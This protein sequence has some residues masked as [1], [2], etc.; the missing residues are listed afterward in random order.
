MISK[1]IAGLLI[2]TSLIC[3]PL[4]SQASPSLPETC[5]SIA[6]IAS[7]K[8]DN[9]KLS[10]TYPKKWAVMQTAQKYDMDANYYWDFA[11]ILDAKSQDEALIKAKNN[12]GIMIM[13]EGPT[14]VG[15]RFLL[16]E[17]KMPEGIR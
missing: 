1:K 8:F 14:H 15:E 6:A 2:T 12:L 13:P 5:P 10:I 7:V 3:L 11:M 16:C 9:A 17:Y 4:I